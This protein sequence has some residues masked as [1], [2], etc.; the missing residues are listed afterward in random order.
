ML[1]ALGAGLGGGSGENKEE[2]VCRMVLTLWARSRGW[3]VTFIG[4]ENSDSSIGGSVGE[5]T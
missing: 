3:R 5:G 2:R 1:W 4:E